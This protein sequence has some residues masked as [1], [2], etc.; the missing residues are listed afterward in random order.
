MLRFI[1]EKRRVWE[2]QSSVTHKVPS[3]KMGKDS[4][5]SS[6]VTGQAVMVLNWK[7]VDLD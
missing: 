2:E 3:G 1:P 5:P 6:V 7:I 4:L